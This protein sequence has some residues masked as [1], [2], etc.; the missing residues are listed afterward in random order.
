MR[1]TTVILIAAIM[2]VSAS[3]FAQ[4]ISLNKSNASLEDII[5][6]L[7]RQCNCNFV[8]PGALLDKAKS[9]NIKVRDVA[10]EKVLDQ[11][12]ENQPITYEIN[13][14]TVTLKAKQRTLFE[15][16]VTRLLAIDVS[17]KVVD[18]LTGSPLAGATVI[19]KGQQQGVR[20]AKDGS[21]TLGNVEERATILIRYTGYKTK[22]LAPSRDLGTI[23]MD[24]AVGNL[25]EV[26]VT[27]NTGYQRI[28]PEQ[29]TGAVSQL[30]TK[31]YEAR[32]STNFLDGLVNRLPGLMINN[33]VMFNSTIPGGAAS[34]RAL[35]NIRGI[36]TMS[37][38]Q[39]PLIVIDGYPTELTMDM[40]DPNEIKSVTILKDAAAATVYGVR[41]SN[42]V[43][44]IER[45]QAS[46]GRPI[47]NFRATTGITPKE[48]FN[49]YRWADNA[50]AIV[51]D[52]QRT[53]QAANVNSG[54]WGLLS[55]DGTQGGVR[56]SPVYYILAKQAANIISA[57]QAAAAFAE[58]S[59]YDNID[60]YS[61]LFLRNSVTNTYNFNVSGGNDNALYYVTANYTGNRNPQVKSND[62]RFSLSA[63]STIRFTKRLGLELTTD[64][65]EQRFNGASVPGITDVYPYERF[66]DV[67]GNPVSIIGSSI[68]PGYNSYIM[69]Q[70]LEDH[71]YHPLIDMDEIS[72]KT[73]AVNNR[74]TANFKYD[75]GSGFDMTFGGI[76]ETSRSDYKHNA[77]ERSSET[78][79][80]INSYVVRNADGTFKYYIPKGGF[81][82]QTASSTSSY[83]ARAQLNYN[84]QIAGDHSINGI[85]GAEV[86][87]LIEKSNTASYFGYNDETLL[88]QPV[89][90]A[91][92]N[93]AAIRGAFLLGAPFQGQNAYE[94]LFNQQYVEDRFLSGYGNVVYS[95]KNTYSLTGS[96]RIDQSNLF[97]T[98]P[99]YKYKPLWSAGAAW[100]IHKEDFM[101]NADWI[102]QLKLRMA[103][104]FNGNVAK[105]SLPEV[106]ARAVL[107]NNTAPT[108]QALRLVSYANSSLRW[109][110]TKNFNTG[111]DYQIFKNISGSI[112][113]Y[114][115][116][117]DDLLGNS[118]I[119]P[120]I[121]VSPTLINK[122][123]IK[124]NGIEFA[125][126]A[127]WIATSK[128]NWNTGIVVARNTSK[129]LDVLQR[130]SFAPEVLNA[131]G[132]VKNY[133]VGA[134]FSYRYAGLDSAGYSLIKDAAGNLY[135]TNDNRSGNPTQKLM[136]SDTSGVSHYSG[137]SIPTINAGL[138]NRVD[139]G[140]FYIFCMI[141]YY[142]GFKVRVPRANPASPR[143]LE[144][145]GN[146][147]KT[148]GDEN[149]TDVMSLP[150]YFSAN[151]NNAYNYADS[152]VV[153]GDYITLADLTVSY[154]FDKSNFIK[155][156]GFSHFELKAQA[157]NLLTVGMNK[158]NFS[159]ATGGYQ[160]SYLTPTYTIG[161]FT[162]F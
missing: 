86:R 12:F 18:S 140:N 146:Y 2:Q 57:D 102:K 123:T 76:Y 52:Y 9:V 26:G 72:D 16:I 93:T 5:R 114:Q 67:N 7:K 51:T 118:M 141:N 90:Y 97:G 161:L 130:G 100:N 148:R 138:S 1:L 44:V 134:M 107:N 48:N 144:G 151:S 8:V 128:V 98:N 101:E 145:S 120:T 109:E 13:N 70:G 54:T 15:N 33:N 125:L 74:I 23:R 82:R 135:H 88:Q 60:D 24:Y 94:S 105:L 108:S 17:G 59:S 10:F 116:K 73:H 119:D 77:S 142:G 53:T 61:R 32:I 71:A 37:A 115:K 20:T 21:F 96:I 83:T 126:R 56:R 62:N 36:S 158:Y 11:I 66:E 121:G 113:Y 4:K 104:G 159:M 147:W 111:L 112:D 129:V 47:F 6:D 81:L 110:Q 143:P 132:Y 40:I 19:V 149:I 29:S 136:A 155:K 92:I 55:T 49:R 3:G 152:Y 89:D 80:Y 25:Q 14:N 78:K 22:E 137:S 31:E 99:K 133:P 43:I 27:V 50:S 157:S 79:Q 28:K 160:K 45:K 84:K 68:A 87:N 122:A 154:S 38:N 117:S 63:R 153:N 127:D 30:S 95:Y 91:A 106:I 46:I 150:A 103:Y 124:N 39:S 42:G 41:A 156:A 34:S 69:S 162:T 64:Y 131:L 58:Y 75:I 35:F 85:I 65:Q 139:I